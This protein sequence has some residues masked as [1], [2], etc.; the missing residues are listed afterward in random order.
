[1]CRVS[2]SVK[3]GLINVLDGLES[4]IGKKCPDQKVATIKFNGSEFEFGENFILKE[5]RKANEKKVE[6]KKNKQIKRIVVILESP[7]NDEFNAEITGP[8]LGKTG[9]LFEIYFIESFNKLYSKGHSGIEENGYEIIF[10]N[11]IQY[12]TSLGYDTRI[13]RD[14]VWLTLWCND[15][16]SIS[17]N[18]RLKGY[19]P[20]IIINLC[21]V[22]LHQNV[23][24]N[25]TNNISYKFIESLKLGVEKDEKNNLYLN[26]KVI[27]NS[28]YYKEHYTLNGFVQTSIDLLYNNDSYKNVILLTGK[29][30]SSWSRNEKNRILNNI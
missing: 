25:G 15:E 10:M 12:K 30:P 5:E 18:D 28:K 14:R 29:H 27:Y 9:K 19:E 11:S 4:E 13:F 16:I 2:N 6:I 17:F 23:N 8:A 3:S 24:E 26:S 22:G 21:T 1:M 20:D 7:H